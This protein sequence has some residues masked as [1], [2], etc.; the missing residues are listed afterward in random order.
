[1]KIALAQINYTLG[2]IEGNVAKIALAA[3]QARE[4]G[5][6]LLVT[7]ELA[8]C[9]Y[10]PRD[11]LLQHGFIDAC[12]DA[13]EQLAR[14]QAKDGLAILVGFPELRTAQAPSLALPDRTRVMSP[15]EV[16]ASLEHLD[17]TPPARGKPLHNAVALLDGG[18]VKGIARK[19]LLPTYNVFNEDR[20]FHSVVSAATCLELDGV[21][22]GVHICEDGWNDARFWSPDERLHERDP[23][24]ELVNDGAQVLINLSASPWSWGRRAGDRAELRVQLI[25]NAAMRYKLPALLVNQIG[26]HD[27]VIYDGSSAAVDASGAMLA[28]LA[29]FDE[30]F[31]LIDLAIGENQPAAPAPIELAPHVGPARIRQALEL[32]VRDYLRKC[33]FS[34]VLLGLSGGIDSALVA[35]IAC[36][37]IGAA[38]VRCIGLPTSYSSE[39]SISD[40][41]KLAENLGCAFEVMPIQSAFDA[42]LAT[43]TPHF[44][45]EQ[46]AFGL[47]EENLQP[48]IRG[49]LLMA[50]S[51]KTG[52][53]LL[54]TGN[55]SELAVGYST[56]YGDMCGALEVI[57]DLYKWQVVELCR[58][59]NRAAESE[60][61]PEAIISKEPSAELRPDQRDTDSL[62]PYPVLDRVL[63]AYVEE[64]LARDEIIAR[65]CEGSASLEF[66][67]AES[68]VDRILRLVDQSEYKR[69]QAPPILRV[70]WRSF[71]SPRQLPLA[72]RYKHQSE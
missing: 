41:Q 19:R 7:S 43:V 34:E 60:L 26:A 46:R 12:R 31:Q 27:D 8:V 5:A 3:K 35:A 29:S 33:S 21:K 23:V 16:A 14:E 25:A 39:G 1:M 62:P 56:L 61:I 47:T 44:T 70:S 63:E 10:A 37:A 30:D 15:S 36:H 66:E 40:S 52:A 55:K 22:L 38:N 42:M 32:G 51:N 54:A 20:Y 11:L 68:L 45:E 65:L 59:Y 9:G 49:T 13:I 57:G 28:Q 4:Q 67:E 48:R 69:W 18:E 24:E 58:E 6:R 71:G 72:Q 53:M 2:D 64:A 50:L 17:D